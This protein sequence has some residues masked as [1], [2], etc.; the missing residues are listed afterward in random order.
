[1][2]KRLTDFR[3]LSFDCYGTLIDW[4]TGLLAALRPWL[5]G[6]GIAEGDEAVL[7]AFARHES[8]QQAETPSMPYP[9]ILAR[10]LRRLAA[11]WGVACRDADAAA[12]GRSIGGWPAFAD[13]PAALRSL[14]RHHRLVVLSNVDRRSFAASNARLGVDFD[15]VFTAEDIGC[16]KPDP[17]TFA[18]LVDRL[19]ADGVAPSDVLHVAQSLYHDHGPAR[20]AGL[21][22]CWIDRRAG[23]TGA[24]ATPPPPAGA[25]ADFRFESLAGLVEAHRGRTPPTATIERGENQ[26]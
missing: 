1:M 12:F 22:T 24:G 10:V 9:L 18:Y 21:A 5:D 20:R 25:T 4:E 7:E 17:R 11:D 23:R 26:G 8:A 2:A 15:H 6:N 19:A 13:S 16:Y 3:V 14:K